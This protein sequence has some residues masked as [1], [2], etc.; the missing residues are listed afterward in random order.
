MVDASSTDFRPNSAIL[1]GKYFTVINFDAD[2][3]KIK[4]QCN[5][6]IGKTIIS[7]S[8]NALSNFTTHLKVS[9]NLTSKKS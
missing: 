4:A 8:T 3:V 2:G 7:G 1:D 9:K 5:S 6:C